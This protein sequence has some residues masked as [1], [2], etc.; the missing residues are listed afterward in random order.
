MNKFSAQRR[1]STVWF[2]NGGIIALIFV[3]FTV[4]GRFGARSSDGWQWFSQN[5]VPTLT[6]M[7]G[8]FAASFGQKTSKAEV[9]KFYFQL[10]YYI[11]IFYFFILYLTIFLAPLAFEVTDTSFIDLL[12]N[13][14][15]Y[16]NILQGIATFALGLF[17]TKKEIKEDA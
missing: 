7:L 1:L 6:L 15:I 16:L 4:V 17:F 8:T 10:A 12:N 11:S 5:I 13:S 9:D 14:K 3:V 2:I